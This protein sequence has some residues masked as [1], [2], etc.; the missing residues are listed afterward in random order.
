[1]PRSLKKGPFVDDHL[2]KKVDVQNEKNTKQ[3]IKTWS[4]RSTI[5]PEIAK[6]AAVPIPA[7]TERSNTQALG[8]VLYTH[9]VYFFQIAGL[10]LLVA[11][12]GAIV[13]TLKHRTNVK[14]QNIS[15]QVART[16]ETAVSIV[17][18]KPGQ[19]I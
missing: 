19:G 18:V 14:R 2:L 10:V 9:Y 7:L 5:S 15:A 3:V 1:M 13:L 17:K 12:I 4:R 8:D 16:P 11:M 6:K